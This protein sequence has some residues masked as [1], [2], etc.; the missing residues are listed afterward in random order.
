MTTLNRKYTKENIYD[1]KLIIDARG[2]CLEVPC[3]PQD[4][5]IYDWCVQQ[6]TI[7]FKDRLR[8]AKKVFK[9]I[10]QTDIFEALL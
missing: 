5:P 10:P 2:D 8:Y 6:D 1:L 9:K 7:L 3:Y 4:C